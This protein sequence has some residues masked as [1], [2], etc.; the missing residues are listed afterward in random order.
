M[1]LNTCEN[2]DYIRNSW[3]EFVE[4]L[5]ENVKDLNIKYFNLHL[6]YVM[7]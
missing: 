5:Y 4:K 2:I 3:I 1:E 6:G 7:M